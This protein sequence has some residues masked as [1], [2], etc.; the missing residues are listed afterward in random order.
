MPKGFK[1]AMS[2]FIILA[3]LEVATSANKI[4]FTDFTADETS[5]KIPS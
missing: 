5:G 1:T 3:D 2:P 4:D